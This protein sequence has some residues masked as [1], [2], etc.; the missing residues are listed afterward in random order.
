MNEKIEKNGEKKRRANRRAMRDIEIKIHC[1][2]L[3]VMVGGEAA[4]TEE[5]HGTMMIKKTE[6]LH[7]VV[8]IFGK[9]ARY[10][11]QFICGSFD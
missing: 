8:T 11:M 6:N 5:R 4:K 9:C 7:R 10:F 1:K 2:S 3:M